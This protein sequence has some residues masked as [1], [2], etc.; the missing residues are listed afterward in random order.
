VGRRHSLLAAALLFLLVP[1]TAVGSSP[2]TAIAPG[3][4]APESLSVPTISGTA[5]V[6]QPLT[7]DDGSW[8]GPSVKYSYQWTH[9]DT[10]GASCTV[11]AGAT[12]KTLLLA[13][14]DV[15]ST[16]RVV[17]SAT[18]KN[19]LALATSNP[20]AVVAPGSTAS[21]PPPASTTSSTTTSTTTTSTAT[22][23]TTTTP[24][25]ATL[26]TG[27]GVVRFG[28]S[29]S[30][31]S[32][33]DRYGYVITGPANIDLVAALSAKG[34]IYRS[35]VQ[36]TPTALTNDEAILGCVPVQNARANGW[37]LKNSSGGEIVTPSYGDPLADPGNS[38]YRQACATRLI[39]F[40]G[41][42]HADGVFFD[43]VTGDSLNVGGLPSRP[44]AYPT[45]QAWED[46][47]VGFV[48]YVGG[49]LK[50]QGFYV[51]ANAS[52]WISGDSGSDTGLLT[53]GFWQRLAPGASGLMTE[54]WLQNP[55]NVSQLR[56][57]GS[58]WYNN[59]T[60]WQ[61]LVSVAQNA[62][63][64]FFGLTYGASTDTRAMVYG[65]ACFLLDWNGKGGAFVWE[66]SNSLDPWNSAWATAIGTPSAAKYQ[67]GAG[68]RRDYSAGT[69]LVNP[70]TSS[71]TFALGGSYLLNGTAVTSVTL[72]PGTAALLNKA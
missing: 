38:A 54:Y 10:K 65:K 7:A 64:D 44:P 39:N 51:V 53:A 32:G 35:A 52:K 25:P 36:L 33:Y 63:V 24:L 66:P 5:S 29:W 11:L 28:N 2:Q 42:H 49:A 1:A 46:A 3:Q 57:A 60:G 68:W 16:I 23:T 22:T 40:L 19:G 41:S 8:G 12:G 59:W 70:G 56:L 43:D 30:S 21:A 69:A 20:T 47:I 55:N 62:G 34:L 72:Q 15:G 17:V 26:G 61:R 37:I 27:T 14:S 9:C 71:Q 18:N 31:G 58:E 4:A 45:A 50:S 6:G 13:P 67:V 48:N